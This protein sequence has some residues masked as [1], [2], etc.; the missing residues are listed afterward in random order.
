MAPGPSGSPPPRKRRIWPWALAAGVVGVLLTGGLIVGLVLVVANSDSGDDQT[1]ATEDTS[2]STTSTTTTPAPKPYVKPRSNR[3]PAVPL[4]HAV[5]LRTQDSPR[6]RVTAL[7][8]V[9]PVRAGSYSLP[10]KRGR[11]W[12]GVRLRVKGLGPGHLSDAP[13]NAAKL[14]STAHSYKTVVARPDGCRALP[15]LVE[16]DPGEQASGC[17]IF[18]VPS[19]FQA[20][21]LQLTLSSGYGPDVATWRLTRRTSDAVP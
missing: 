16:L 15:V 7:T 14:R 8:V 3:L 11:H 21:R 20:T 4:G 1:A 9:D 5:D 6:A 2:P 19:G 12:V 10:P 18:E 13:G 17:L